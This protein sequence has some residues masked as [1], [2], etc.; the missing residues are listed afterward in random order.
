MLHGLI[1]ALDKMLNETIASKEK[2][3]K[4]IRSTLAQLTKTQEIRDKKL[5]DAK[6]RRE[7][8]EKENQFGLL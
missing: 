1:D 5:D 2:K 3:L 6:Q 7:K 8:L 4:D